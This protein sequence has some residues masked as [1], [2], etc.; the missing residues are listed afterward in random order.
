MEKIKMITASKA[1][2]LYN[3]DDVYK[4]TLEYLNDRIQKAAMKVK[5]RYTLMCI[6]IPLCKG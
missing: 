4:N 3:E 2:E 5:L 6:V 1:R